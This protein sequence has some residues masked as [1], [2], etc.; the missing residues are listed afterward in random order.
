MMSKINAIL[1]VIVTIYFHG[2]PIYQYPGKTLSDGQFWHLGSVEWPAGT[3]TPV[4][5]VTSGV[6]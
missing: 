6:P 1:A 3:V 4:D 2:S 5:S